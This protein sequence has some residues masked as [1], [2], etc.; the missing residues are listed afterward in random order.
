MI[1]MV[2]YLCLNAVAPDE[3][4]E[5]TAVW[6]MRP[7]VQYPT[8]S[9]CAVASMQMLPIIEDADDATHPLIHCEAK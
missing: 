1:K 9:G 6:V 5:G 4:N 2:I 8:P 3:C 7:A